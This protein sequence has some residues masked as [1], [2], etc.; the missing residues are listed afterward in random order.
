MQYRKDIQILRGVAVLL[1]VFFHLGF[2]GFT[3]GFLGVDVFF[4]ISGYLMAVMY[5]PA[6]KVDFFVK[7]AKRLL[8]AYFAA[9]IA[10]LL[11]AAAIT[12][13]SE[14][15]QVA[16]QAAFA[17][18][19]SSNIGFWLD[20]S[21][22]DKSAFKPLLH[23]WSLGVEIQ[24]YLCV[25]LLVWIFQKVRISYF[26]VLGASALLCFVV[27]GIS[28]KTA[29]FWMPLRLWEFLIGFGVAKYLS[30]IRMSQAPTGRWLGAAALV[31]IVCIPFFPVHG[32]AINFFSGHPGLVALLIS[33]ATATTLAFGL[34]VKAESNS[35][36]TLLE[37]IGGY[38]YSIYLAHFP[39]IV[40]FLYQPFAGTVLKADTI[41]QT[42]LLALLVVVAS[43]LLYAFVERPFRSMKKP[44]AW[45][46]AAVASVL[47]L[48]PLGEQ[49]QKLIFPQNE[50]LVYQAWKDRSPYRCG[51]LARITDPRAISCEL[52]TGLVSPSNRILLVGNSHADAIKTT[53][54]SVAQARGVAV[55]FMVENTPLMTGGITPT[56]LVKEAKARK[57]DSIVLH[58]APH[59]LEIG[60]LVDLL[61]LAQREG[62]K[63]SLVLPV[64]IW[65]TGVPAMLLA[66][67]HGEAALPVKRLDE[68]RQT[69]GSL[70]S[71][72]ERLEG[73]KTYPVAQEFC[74]PDCRLISS[75]GR[76]LY[77]DSTHLTLTG[78]EMLRGVFERV[79]SDVVGR[80]AIAD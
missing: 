61:R 73:L 71:G 10:T 57:A 70:E 18:F 8:P 49:L 33:L 41:K 36:A 34:P 76:P 50:L 43:T 37:R 20:N 21:Y 16:G 17:A 31:A 51:K 6:K 72:V 7:R 74:H 19:F 5:D 3:S 75:D 40:L 35:V 32:D 56:N 23:L 39:V 53:F 12:T 62:I 45:G 54:S 25:P 64:P 58:Y 80:E 44:M 4:V 30:H 1:V 38:S 67:M 42:I 27:V 63:V 55:W 52:T 65:D 26:L 77:F 60:R 11:L 68:Y 66:S 22:F 47:M 46:V 15:D 59:S 79:V 9:V 48:I 14:F 29:F 78:S 28:P 13:P 69:N 2:S 24:F